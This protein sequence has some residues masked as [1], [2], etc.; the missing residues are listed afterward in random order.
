MRRLIVMRH[1]KS[2]WDTEA[3]TDHARP[4]TS[5][6]QR[7][8]GRVAEQ[9]VQLGWVP[10]QVVSSDAARTLETWERMVQSITGPIPFVATPALYHAGPEAFR[11][12][13]GALP[14]AVRTPLVLGH[15]PGWEQVVAWLTGT[16][17]P[18]G[19]ANAVL[20]SRD[21]DGGWSAALQPES[22]TVTAVL[23]P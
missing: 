7:D 21:G 10:D 11:A 17:V 1:A 8:A 9:L 23:R 13:V 6:G 14:D 3:P 15:N 2:A 18:L 16:L 20:M 5:R 19:T 22:F 4:L 12:V